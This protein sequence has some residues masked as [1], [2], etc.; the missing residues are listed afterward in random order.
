MYILYKIFFELGIGFNYRR[1]SEHSS[2]MEA[3]GHYQSNFE[4]NNEKAEKYDSIDLE[5]SCG[6]Q[7]YS[8]LYGVESM[9][10]TRK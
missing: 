4:A 6:N 8:S 9:K 1:T 3:E 5:S 10:H 2:H 7:G